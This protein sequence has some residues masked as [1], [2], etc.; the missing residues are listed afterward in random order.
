MRGI[1]KISTLVMTL[2]ILVM[3]SLA[4]AADQ[5]SSSAEAQAKSQPAGQ[6]DLSLWQ[7][8]FS[9]PSAPKTDASP[10]VNLWLQRYSDMKA[11]KKIEISKQP[12]VAQPTVPNAFVNVVSPAPPADQTSATVSLS[13][14]VPGEIYSAW[15]DPLGPGPGIPSVIGTS[16][17]PALG[18]PGSWV[19][20]P[21]GPILPPTIGP[22]ATFVRHPS[23]GSHPLG[24]HIVGYQ[25]YGGGVG[26]LG[27][28]AIWTDATSG[29][30][31]AWGVFGPL[32]PVA[33]SLPAG[34]C[35]DYFDYPNTVIDDVPFLAPP[36]LGAVFYTWTAF[37]DLDG[38]PNLNGNL[39]DDPAD[40]S[41]IAFS[42][43]NTLGG[44]FPFPGPTSPPIAVNIAGAP[45]LALQSDMAVVATPGIVLPGALYVAWTDGY[46]L[47]PIPQPGPPPEGMAFLPTSIWIDVSPAPGAGAPFGFF[48]GN[49]FVAPVAPIGPVIGGGTQAMSTVTVAVSNAVTFPNPCPPTAVYVAWADGSLGDPDIFFSASFAGGSPGTWTP[50]IRVNQDVPGNGLDQW[51]PSMAVDSLGNINIIFY[52]RRMDPGNVL[53]EVWMASSFDCGATWTD[54]PLSDGGPVPPATTIPP[55]YIGDYLEID[56]NAMNGAGSIWNDSRPTFGSQEVWFENTKPTCTAKAGDANASNT[57]GLSDVIAMVNYIFNKPGCIP[58]PTCWLSGLLCRGDWN[59]SGNVGLNDVIRAVN[60]IFNKPGGPWLA[61]PIGQCCALVP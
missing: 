33:V 8:K 16:F 6:I 31:T 59:G 11:G 41:Y 38:D 35:T 30:G 23:M 40:A 49:V 57:Y 45:T 52:D 28:S 20:P 12:V 17:S 58:T 5:K 48:G 50:P 47:G 34:C 13:E 46:V 61:V 15:T 4:L 1:Y 55:G 29:G 26:F 39:F 56:E 3:F 25:G 32:P 60:Y 10:A 19:P 7:K 36:E 9:Q 51:A 54:M 22:P 53:T 2:I 18:I 14:F 27:G 44:P 24:G 21:S 42:F 37:D 43:G